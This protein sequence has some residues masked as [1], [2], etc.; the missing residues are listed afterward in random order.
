MDDDD[1]P[2]SFPSKLP[3]LRNCVFYVSCVRVRVCMHICR[4]VFLSAVLVVVV[5]EVVV[6]VVVTVPGSAKGPGVRY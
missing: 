2:D 3:F 4:Y 1:T 5:V 6:V